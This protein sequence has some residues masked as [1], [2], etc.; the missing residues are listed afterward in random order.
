MKPA[1][2]SDSSEAQMQ[3]LEFHF[4]F[5]RDAFNPH[6]CAVALTLVSMETLLLNVPPPLH[7]SQLFKSALEFQS[8]SGCFHQCSL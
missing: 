3:T 8:F 6:D 2:I 5:R 1:L 7:H 4:L